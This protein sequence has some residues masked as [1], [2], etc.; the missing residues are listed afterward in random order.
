MIRFATQKTSAKP[1][2]FC[3]ATTGQSYGCHASDHL[4]RIYPCYRCSHV[5]TGRFQFVFHFDSFIREHHTVLSPVHD[6]RLDERCEGQYV[7]PSHHDRRD[8]QPRGT[9]SGPLPE[10]A[11]SSAQRFSFSTFHKSSG[12]AKC[13]KACLSGLRD[14]KVAFDSAIT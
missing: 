9:V 14:R 13:T 10:I 4:V 12:V 11:L 3:H 7:S 5:L 2:R 6:P 1:G 8:R